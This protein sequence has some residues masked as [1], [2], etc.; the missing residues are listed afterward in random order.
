MTRAM[1]VAATLLVALSGSPLVRADMVEDCEQ[2]G[3]P[4]RSLAGCTALIDSGQW[5]EVDLAWAY[6]NRGNSRR[7]LLR[8]G[9]AFDDFDRAIRIDPGF[10]PAWNGRGLANIDLERF[11]RAI[12]DLD[13]AIRLDVVFAEAYANRGLAYCGIDQ[14][15]RA[16]EDL[17]YAIWLDRENDAAYHVR[18]IAYLGLSRRLRA[19]EDFDQAIRLNPDAAEYYEARAGVLSE[20][21]RG[22][23]AIADYDRLIELSPGNAD[24]YRYRGIGYANAGQHERAI[25]DFDQAIRFRPH[26]AWLYVY[27]AQVYLDLQEQDR[28][29]DDFDRALAVG[30][31]PAADA[32]NLR[33]WGSYIHLER[34]RTLYRQERHADGFPHIDEALAVMPGNPWA[35]DMRAHLHAAQGRID[36]ALADFDRAIAA[37]GDDIVRT[38]QQALVRHGHFSGPADGV[39]SASTRAALVACLRA[40]CRLL[41]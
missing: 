41:E 1:V 19:V 28:A 23:E 33:R 27:R 14:H 37:G 15:Q 20:L 38:Y 40:G 5:P 31:L 8:Y 34:A 32:D 10:A 17:D 12:E 3:D 6:V 9:Q 36:D 11:D 4:D 29:L 24:A 16:I 18:G 35:F 30:T 26:D 7:L 39:Y 21:R 13:E 25:R 22:D 2:Q